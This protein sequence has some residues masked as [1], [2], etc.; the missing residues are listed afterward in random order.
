MTDDD[1]IYYHMIRTFPILQEGPM[2]VA[3]TSVLKDW[4]VRKLWSSGPR[5]LEGSLTFAGRE[6]VKERARKLGYD[7]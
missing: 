6:Y 3:I 7:L 2:K 4:E 5:I 1:L